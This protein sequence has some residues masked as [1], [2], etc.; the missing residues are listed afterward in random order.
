M[1]RTRSHLALVALLGAALLVLPALGGC[2]LT[3]VGSPLPTRTAAP[4]ATLESTLGPLD[5]QGALSQ[6]ALVLV[7]YRGHW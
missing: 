3:T 5:T 4:A 2:R 6:S 7:F 1:R